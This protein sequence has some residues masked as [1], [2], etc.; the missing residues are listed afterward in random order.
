[1]NAASTDNVSTPQFKRGDWVVYVPGHADGSLLHPDC[2]QGTVSSVG[3][4][5]RIVFVVYKDQLH[6]KATSPLDL[7]AAEEYFAALRSSRRSERQPPPNGHGFRNYL[8]DGLYVDF[9]GFNVVLTAENGIA[10]HDIVYLEPSV[11]GAFK[12]WHAARI[13][14]LFPKG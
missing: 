11:F 13:A 7:V 2:E 3:E 8:G 12:A 6:P 14:P 1:M 4:D 10:A 9:D 5:S